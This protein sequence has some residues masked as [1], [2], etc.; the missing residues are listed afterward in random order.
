[1]AYAIRGVTLDLLLNTHF[2][3]SAVVEGELNPLLS[4]VQHDWTG[5][6]RRGLLHIGG[7]NGRLTH[8]LRMKSKHGWDIPGTLAEKE[9]ETYPPPGEDRSCLPGDGYVPAMWRHVNAM[10]IPKPCRSS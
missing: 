8:S 7:W 1:M 5:G 9:E 6:L 4:A 10:F 2:P 3:D